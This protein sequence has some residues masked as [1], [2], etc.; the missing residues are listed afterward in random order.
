M[1]C[2]PPFPSKLN[3]LTD[4]EGKLITEERNKARKKGNDGIHQEGASMTQK[5]ITL[6]LLHKQRE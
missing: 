4:F 1:A 5:Q 3:L 2:N 6:C